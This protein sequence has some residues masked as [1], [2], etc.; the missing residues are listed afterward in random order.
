MH[1]INQYL[2]LAIKLGE[3]MNNNEIN[4]ENL[5][6][7]QIGIQRCRM[8]VLFTSINSEIWAHSTSFKSDH[9]AREKSKVNKMPSF[10]IIYFYR[11][12]KVKCGVNSLQNSTKKET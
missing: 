10:V 5:Q 8:C 12:W 3:F 2:R 1:D 7:N 6:C 11:G 9:H 4:N